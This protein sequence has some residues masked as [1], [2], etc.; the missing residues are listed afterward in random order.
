[1]NTQPTKTPEHPKLPIVIDAFDV[2]LYEARGAISMHWSWSSAQ[3]SYFVVIK[4]WKDQGSSILY[5][6]NHMIG[7]KLPKNVA[8]FLSDDP[9]H[10][11]ELIKSYKFLK[12]KYARVRKKRSRAKINPVEPIVW[13][14]SLSPY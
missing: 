12:P 10:L 14:L 7:K 5:F 6:K 4:S 3:N 1:M 13:D 2:I 11:S 9:T 8:V